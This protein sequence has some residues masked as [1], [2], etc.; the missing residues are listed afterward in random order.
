MTE[1]QNNPQEQ[2]KKGTPPSRVEIQLMLWDNCKYITELIAD[3]KANR[4]QPCKKWTNIVYFMQSQN[5]LGKTLLD[6]IKDSEIDDL[7]KQIQEI[8]TTL[9]NKGTIKT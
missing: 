2:L 8:K 5:A 4:K 9:E 6:S 1:P 3:F 7:T